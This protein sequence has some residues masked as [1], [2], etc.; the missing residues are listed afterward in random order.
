M[1]ACDAMFAL[2]RALVSQNKRRF[3]EGGFDLDLTYVHPRIIVMGYPSS[4]FETVY[5][6]PRSEVVRLLETRHASQ[7]FVYNFC[8]ERNR[9]YPASEFDGRAKWFPVEDH[10]V[11]TLQQA[12]AFCEDAASWLAGDERRVVA[13]HCKAGKGRAGMMA[14]ML[15]LRMGY[16]SSAAGAIENYNSIRVSDRLGLTVTSQ[17]K[18][19]GYYEALLVHRRHLP[20][21]I[22]PSAAPIGLTPGDIVEPSIVVEQLV[23]RN[24]LTGVAPPELRLRVFQLDTESGKKALVCE[25]LGRDRFAVDRELR[26]CISFEFYRVP[27][28]DCSSKKHFKVWLN[29]LLLNS[30]EVAGSGSIRRRVTVVARSEMDWVRRDKKMRRFPAAFELEMTFTL[31]SSGDSA[32]AVSPSDVVCDKAPD[33][34]T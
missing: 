18:W 22:E 9:C 25:E 23:L 2:P 32:G 28:G 6:N 16:A 17:K 19:V 11:P 1:V 33:K 14:C 27:S 13:L 4:G 15:L 7:Y 10:N 21:Q 24:T 34:T 5:R 30:T 26:G 3:Q 20:G 8:D 29:S 12:V 31:R